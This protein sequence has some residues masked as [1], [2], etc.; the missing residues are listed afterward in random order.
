VLVLSHR[1]RD[2]EVVV[3]VRAEEEGK[4]T[5]GYSRV[6]TLGTKDA[7]K[8]LFHPASEVHRRKDMPHS[9]DPDHGEQ[10]HLG[11]AELQYKITHV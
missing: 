11:M 5:H 1:Q 3:A 6:Q 9:W 7:M 4:L 2:R 10:E 8:K